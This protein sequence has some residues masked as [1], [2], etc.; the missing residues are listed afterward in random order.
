MTV[1][2]SSSKSRLAIPH[3]DITTPNPAANASVQTRGWTSPSDIKTK[4]PYS[5]RSV[6]IL[7]LGSSPR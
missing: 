5:V 2:N 3:S 6:L 4:L 1:I 7:D